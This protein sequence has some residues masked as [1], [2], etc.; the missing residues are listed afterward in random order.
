M[1][2]PLLQ[3][4]V[5]AAGNGILALF[6]LMGTSIKL[7]SGAIGV[8]IPLLAIRT[9]EGVRLRLLA[10]LFLATHPHKMG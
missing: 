9:Y 5:E 3:G 2:P 1:V 10:K 6:F 7:I 4:A 8:V